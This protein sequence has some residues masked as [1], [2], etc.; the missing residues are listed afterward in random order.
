MKR[1]ICVLLLGATALAAR[2]DVPFLYS[3]S[4]IVYDVARGNPPSEES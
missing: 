4:A 3:R 1:I 2:A